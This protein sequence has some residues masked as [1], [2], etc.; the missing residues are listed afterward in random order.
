MFMKIREIFDTRT[1][2]YILRYVFTLHNFLMMVSPAVSAGFVTVTVDKLRLILLERIL[3]ERDMAHEH[4]LQMF[5][6]YVNIR[7]MRFAVLKV[8][9][10]DW[11]M[12]VLFLN[13]CISYQIIIVQFTQL[14]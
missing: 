12:P 4:H 5:V 14:Y 9:P 11:S 1:P 6:E 2:F 13:L 3:C 8:V 10:L 7:P